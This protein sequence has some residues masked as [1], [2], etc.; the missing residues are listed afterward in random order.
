[1][2]I[3][4]QVRKVQS[5]ARISSTTP[6]A[7]RRK[8]PP[9]SDAREININ[10]FYVSIRVFISRLINKLIASAAGPIYYMMN[11]MRGRGGRVPGTINFN[12]SQLVYGSQERDKS[13]RSVT[14]PRDEEIN[15][16]ICVLRLQSKT[17]RYAKNNDRRRRV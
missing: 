9:S 16:L 12:C 14:A 3:L 6:S 5:R 10:L 17:D 7:R 1:M 4:N 13:K 11:Q 15:Q 8:F 2:R